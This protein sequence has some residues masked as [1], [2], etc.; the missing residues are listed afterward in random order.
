MSQKPETGARTRAASVPRITEAEA[1]APAA[2]SE[3]DPIAN[4]I[5]TV[6]ETV[7]TTP[8]SGSRAIGSPGTEAAA[9]A[10]AITTATLNPTQGITTIMTST[11]DFIAFGQANLEAF[12]KSGQIWA[13][14]MQELTQQ[15]TATAKVSFDE[16]V[17]TFKA[18]SAVKSL[19]DAIELQSRLARS[20]VEKALVES[21]KITNASMK[22]TEQTLAPITARVTAAVQTFGKAA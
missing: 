14:G 22:L 8:G 6:S 7:A 9:H 10:G 17:S 12:V 2:S 11:E 13:A 5:A 18:I 19:K 3:A 20:L 15:M 1:E 21:G 16:S 4:P